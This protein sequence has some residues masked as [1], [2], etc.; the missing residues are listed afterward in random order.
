MFNL[1]WIF[2]LQFVM[3]LSTKHWNQFRE[4]RRD[5]VYD[6]QFFF[7][8]FHWYLFFRSLTPSFLLLSVNG[9]KSTG[10]KYNKFPCRFPPFFSSQ[11]AIRC[12]EGEIN[13]RMNYGS[14]EGGKK[15]FNPL[16]TFFFMDFICFK[17]FLRKFFD[18]KNVLFIKSWFGFKEKLVISKNESQRWNLFQM[19]LFAL[20]TKTWFNKVT[21]SFSP[22][23]ILLVTNIFLLCSVLLNIALYLNIY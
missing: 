15:I 9:W 10:V 8:R 14:V 16:W 6:Q 17:T 4:K 7:I 13:S 23:M 12:D 19:R 21:T 20:N 11:S 1:T 2:Q 18:K 3:L 22:P 5:F